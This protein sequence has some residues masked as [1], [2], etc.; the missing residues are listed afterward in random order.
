MLR[1]A[2]HRT[3]RYAVRLLGHAWSAAKHIDRTLG[4]AA[5]IYNRLAPILTPL[6]AE[7]LGAEKAQSIQGAISRGIAA[8]ERGHQVPSSFA[9]ALNQP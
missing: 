5:R 1:E 3:R 8:R 6:A 4:D 9:G 7:H 2:F